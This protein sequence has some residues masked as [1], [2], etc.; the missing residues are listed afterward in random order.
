MLHKKNILSSKKLII[1]SRT[2]H[3]KS[4]F[5]NS[6]LFPQFR[7]NFSCF[8]LAKINY[9]SFGT[10]IITMFNWSNS[11]LYFIDWFMFNNLLSS[12]AAA[13]KITFLFHPSWN[14]WLIKNLK[15][16]SQP[17]LFRPFP[18][19]FMTCVLNL[20]GKDN[21]VFSKRSVLVNV[22]AFCFIHW[23]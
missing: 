12:D 2:V 14:L 16:L 11:E 21:L 20:A 22:F 6:V 15:L 18:L 9:L 4:I 19:S 7:V 3:H 23:W 5:L 17:A 10:C 8:W 13:F 1:F